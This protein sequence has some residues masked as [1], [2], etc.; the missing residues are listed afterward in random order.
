M[1][2]SLTFAVILTI[3]A[4]TLAGC[5][6]L[7][8]VTDTIAEDWNQ[9]FGNAEEEARIEAERI[10]IYNF[11]TFVCDGARQL[12]VS[13]SPSGLKAS[14]MF[15][16]KQLLMSR[17]VPIQPFTNAP[18]AMYIMDDGTLLLEKHFDVIYKHCKPLVNDT[19]VKGVVKSYDYT[20]T[21][22]PEEARGDEIF[23]EEMRK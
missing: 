6:Q 9:Q 2:H 23:R 20:P 21:I 12:V 13:F 22:T 19:V 14:I 8:Q 16:K 5:T 1:P 18:Y 7:K 4:L 3:S 10:H 11:D 15:E 17:D